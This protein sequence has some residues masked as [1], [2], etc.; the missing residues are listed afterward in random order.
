VFDQCGEIRETTGCPH[1][2]RRVQMVV[3]Y[4]AMKRKFMLHLLVTAKGMNQKL[5]GNTLH[6]ITQL[7]LGATPDVKLCTVV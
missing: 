4:F 3:D 6:S 7:F 1:Q 2:N 5:W